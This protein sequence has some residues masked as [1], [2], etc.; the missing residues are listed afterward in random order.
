MW[1]ARCGA[2]DYP[3]RFLAVLILIL[4]LFACQ[5]RV[6]VQSPGVTYCM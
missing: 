4:I 3:A 5:M 1:I 6:S 2:L